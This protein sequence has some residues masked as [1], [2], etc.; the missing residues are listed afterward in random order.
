MY[1]ARIW[2]HLRTLPT[3]RASDESAELERREPK[4]FPVRGTFSARVLR[5]A[6]LLELQPPNGCYSA[7]MRAAWL[8]RRS[9]MV[10]SFHRLQAGKEMRTG[11]YLRL[12]VM[13]SAQ[14]LLVFTNLAAVVMIFF[15]WSGAEHR[16]HASLDS[17]EQGWAAWLRASMRQN[18]Q[19][20]LLFLM[21]FLCSVYLGLLTPRLC[22]QRCWRWSL[23]KRR[24]ELLQGASLDSPRSLHFVV[25]L[26]LEKSCVYGIVITAI[27]ICIFRVFFH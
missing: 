22:I 11:Q 12:D 3:A 26:G 2:P 23:L 27:I 17:C 8:A 6:L 1:A 25:P 20:S 13:R 14:L 4:L 9:P 24:L 15:G 21:T 18:P 5:R 19:P 16:Q 10:W 7:P